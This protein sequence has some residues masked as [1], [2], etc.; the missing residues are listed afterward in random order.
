MSTILLVGRVVLAAVFAVAAAAKIADLTGLRATLTEFR[1]PPRLVT[2]SSFLLSAAE[3]AIAALLLP[4]ATARIAALAALALLTV[5]C[6]GVAAAL[7]RGEQPD[8][9]CFGRAHSARVGP[10]TLVRNAVLAAGAGLVALAGPGR[11]LDSAVAGIHV[12]ALGVAVIAV[13]TLLAVLGWFGLELFR[14]NG[15]L[16]ERVRALETAVAELG[17]EEDEAT[18]EQLYIAAAG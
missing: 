18:N 15:R 6:V 11:G 8:C 10:S 17:V 14:Q 2:P 1:V 5:F 3:L 4:A 12:S 13:F 16:I 7:R 9:G